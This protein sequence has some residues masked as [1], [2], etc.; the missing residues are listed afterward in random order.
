MF[1]PLQ[2]CAQD[3]SLQL[4][5]A[6]LFENLSFTLKNGE[7]LVINGDNGSG[8]TSLLNAISGLLPILEG[9]IDFLIDEQN[10]APKSNEPQSLEGYINFLAH[11]DGLKPQQTVRENLD[12]WSGFN[13][14]SGLGTWQAAEK[15]DIA[16]L[17]D[18]PVAALSRGQKRRAGFARLLTAS[19]P[20]WLL[21]EP[22]AA[23]D[24]KSCD[25]IEEIVSE[26]L[27][28]NGCA[29]AASH[30][31]F[32][33]GKSHSISINDYAPSAASKKSHDSENW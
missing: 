10:N 30:L 21:D 33:Q 18:L 13:S 16:H 7:A 19:K 24:A 25:L 12:F 31:E 5:D 23:L 26:H 1:N 2:L 9:K 20:I 6:L 29:I 17:L 28:Q 8:K 4:G 11:K 22:T 32:L 14:Q 15:T 3:I 27:G